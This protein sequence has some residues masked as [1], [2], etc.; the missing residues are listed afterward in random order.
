[1]LAATKSQGVPRQR[2]GHVGRRGRE[3]VVANFPDE[4]LWATASR[5]RRGSVTSAGAFMETKRSCTSFGRGRGPRR[6][7]ARACACSRPRRSGSRGRPR[8]AAPRDES[9]LG[10]AWDRRTRPRG[11]DSRL[12]CPSVGRRSRPAPRGWPGRPSR[13]PRRRRAAPFLVW[14][15]QLPSFLLSSCPL[16]RSKGRRDSQEQRSGEAQREAP[17]GAVAADGSCDLLCPARLTKLPAYHPVNAQ[18]KS[19]LRCPYEAQKNP[20]DAR[21]HPR[22]P[23]RLP[24]GRAPRAAPK[25]APPAEK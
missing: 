1:M 23:W 6:R 19:K 11:A 22:P 25:K 3:D 13:R 4:I 24:G 16:P 18:A 14:R 17:A 8:S 5:T 15:P 12:L 7:P 10:C 9:G 20:Q 2:L 21:A